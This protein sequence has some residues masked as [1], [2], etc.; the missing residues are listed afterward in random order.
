ME[1]RL[2][3]GHAPSC[4]QHDPGCSRVAGY[5]ALDRQSQRGICIK[6]D[7]VFWFGQPGRHHHLKPNHLSTGGGERYD[8]SRTGDHASVIEYRLELCLFLFS[9]KA[10]PIRDEPGRLREPGMTEPARTRGSLKRLGR[11]THPHLVSERHTP[12]TRVQRSPGSDRPNSPARS[13]RTEDQGGEHEPRIDTRADD[14]DIPRA[15]LT[16]EPARKL[17]TL[18]PR[19]SE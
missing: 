13:T 8:L 15:S 19:V 7:R 17:W 2:G 10:E 3:T 4:V 6:F 9:P 14:R 1:P 18:P 12:R 5:P 16:V 11:H